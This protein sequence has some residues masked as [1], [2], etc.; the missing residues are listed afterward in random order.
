MRYVD[1][2][3]N[4]SISSEPKRRVF[5]SCVQY[6]EE[7]ARLIDA[8]LED[9]FVNGRWG[10]LKT[11]QAAEDQM[12][13]TAAFKEAENAWRERKQWGKIDPVQAFGAYQIAAW[14]Y[15]QGLGDDEYD[16]V[17]DAFPEAVATLKRSCNPDDVLLNCGR[18]IDDSDEDSPVDH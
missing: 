15:L 13:L 11:P 4:I 2:E 12:I 18:D 7:A 14:R 17:A 9:A 3:G 6:E 16:S 1:L 8:L 10:D 5:I